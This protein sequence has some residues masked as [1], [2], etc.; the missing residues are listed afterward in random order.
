MTGDTDRV[1]HGA[2]QALVLDLTTRFVPAWVRR[3]VVSRAADGSLW[4]TDGVSINATGAD[5]QELVASTAE[6][7]WLVYGSQ[8][9]I[10]AEDWLAT[11]PDADPELAAILRDL[12][13]DGA[14]PQRPDWLADRIDEIASD[15]EQWKLVYNPPRGTGEAFA[16]NPAIITYS[17]LYEAAARLRRYAIEFD[18]DEAPPKM[19]IARVRRALDALDTGQVQLALDHLDWAVTRL[20]LHLTPEHQR[21]T[22]PPLP[23][24]KDT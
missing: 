19:A 3:L 2:T 5:Y 15:V 22:Y 6:A 20:R 13:A 8:I 23:P 7:G 1:D 18:A 14:R 4:A 12:I 24:W 21:P 17:P 11:H 16:G 9:E 10:R